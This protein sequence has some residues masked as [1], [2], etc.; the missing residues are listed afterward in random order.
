MKKYFST[1]SFHNGSQTENLTLGILQHRGL[2]ELGTAFLSAD[3]LNIYNKFKVDRRR[4]EFLAGRYIAKESVRLENAD[5]SP[6]AINIV[7]GVW[8]FPLI[9][10][11]GLHQATVSIGHTDRCATAIFYSS[12]THPVGIDIEEIKSSNLPA[13]KSFISDVEQE[14]ITSRQLPY[15]DA[16]YVIWSAKEAAGKALRVGFTIPEKLYTISS[17]NMEDDIYH[18]S[19]EKLPMLKVIGWVCD[20]FLICIAFPSVWNLQKIERI[21]PA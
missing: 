20:E 5:L 9:H 14:L 8:G 17:M 2:A 6:N 12:N 16:M 10:S 19:F 21:P 7:H 18:I 15:L 11:P 13:F 4:S 3:E 1:L